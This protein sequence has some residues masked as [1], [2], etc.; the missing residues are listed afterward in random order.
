MMLA[1]VKWP[2]SASVMV[3]GDRRGG[4]E[5][6]VT[7]V[8]QVVGRVMTARFVVGNL[9]MRFERCNKKFQVADEFLLRD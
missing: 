8:T 2:K 7:R 4:D 6:R 5:E 3:C 1:Q 9:E